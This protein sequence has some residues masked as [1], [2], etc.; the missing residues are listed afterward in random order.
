MTTAEQR[1]RARKTRRPIDT[2]T[3]QPKRQ[4]RQSFQNWTCEGQMD[5]FDPREGQQS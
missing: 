4:R 2:S 1:V 3:E 5:L